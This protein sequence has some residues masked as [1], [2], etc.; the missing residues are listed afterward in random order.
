MLTSSKRP[1]LSVFTAGTQEGALDESWDSLQRQSFEDWEW[2]IVADDPRW[3]PHP[4]DRRV[5]IILDDV[6]AHPAA[7][8][9]LACAIAMGDALVELHRGDRIDPGALALIWQG[10]ADDPSI[11]LVEHRRPEPGAAPL[12]GFRRSAYLSAGGFNASAVPDLVS[13]LRATTAST[14]VGG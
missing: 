14:Q 10:F 3:R 1:L 13:R 8:K 12:R 11:G 2:I 6:A 7:A 9:E 5:R 4:D